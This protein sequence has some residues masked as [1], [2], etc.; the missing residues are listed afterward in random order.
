MTAAD[1]ARGPARLPTA[2]SS[3]FVDRRARQLMIR[4]V[5]ASIVIIRSPR[6]RAGGRRRGSSAPSG[7]PCCLRIH[8]PLRASAYVRR[9]QRR[10]FPLVAPGLVLP[11]LLNSIR[12]ARCFTGGPV[13]ADSCKWSL[14]SGRPGHDNRAGGRFSQAARPR[15]AAAFSYVFS[16]SHF[17]NFLT[18]KDGKIHTYG[19]KIGPERETQS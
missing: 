3:A 5:Y 17:L 1:V 9:M 12:D 4:R 16:L 7:V 6:R 2:A 11:C 15:H 19:V 18:E 10:V 13:E 8:P 14:S